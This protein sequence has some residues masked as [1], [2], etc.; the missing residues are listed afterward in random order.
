MKI[1]KKKTQVQGWKHH[2]FREQG[3]SYLIYYSLKYNIESTEA[4]RPKLC[5]HYSIKDVFFRLT[6]K[7]KYQR[8]SES[9]DTLGI[10]PYFTDLKKWKNEK[11]KEKKSQ[12]PEFIK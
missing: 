10:F 1:G 5:G 11:R 12:I 9:E 8:I 4:P 6:K 3:S 2:V 7:V